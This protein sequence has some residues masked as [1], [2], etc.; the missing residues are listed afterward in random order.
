MHG[1]WENKEE[2]VL[3]LDQIKEKPTIDYAEDYLNVSTKKEKENYYAVFGQYVLTKDIFDVLK[4]S[5]DENKLEN[6]EI[7][8]TSALEKVRSSIGTIGYLVSGT[9]YDVGLPDKYYE[10]MV[11][12][13][14]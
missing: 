9:S 3:K 12:Y 2:T 14:K 1:K 6:G 13:N 7:Q 10:T 4:Q 11:N 8:L 5:V